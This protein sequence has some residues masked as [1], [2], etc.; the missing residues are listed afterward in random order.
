MDSYPEELGVILRYGRY[1]LFFFLRFS[2]FLSCFL[3]QMLLGAGG[4]IRREMEGSIR[5]DIAF[6]C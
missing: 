3:V 6:G 2:L 4:T 5:R 1:P